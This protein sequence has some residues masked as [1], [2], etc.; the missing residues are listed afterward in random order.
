MITGS[1]SGHMAFWDLE[2]K[3]LKNQILEAHGKG[4]NGLQCFPQEPLMV[5]SSGDNT[6]KV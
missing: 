3:C 4:V 2:K 5:S 6:L 1:A